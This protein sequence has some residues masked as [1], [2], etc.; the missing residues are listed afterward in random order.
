M[1]TEDPTSI[2]DDL[3]EICDDLGYDYG[4]RA[5]TAS[6]CAW[7]AEVRVTQQPN[8][9]GRPDRS[10]VT[11]AVG[12]ASADHVIDQAAADMLDWLDCM[13][14]TAEIRAAEQEYFERLWY[15]RTTSVPRSATE[16][17]EIRERINLIEAAYDDLKSLSPEYVSGALSALR[18]VLGDDWH[19]TDT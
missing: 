10:Y 4:V 17:A 15:H 14:S 3:A 5:E 9:E 18:W 7:A 13:R 1:E 8:L 6:E 16:L 19:N 12:G 11:Y 2:L